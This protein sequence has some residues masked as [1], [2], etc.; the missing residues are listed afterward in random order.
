MSICQLSRLDEGGQRSMLTHNEDATVTWSPLDCDTYQLTQI[1][2]QNASDDVFCRNYPPHRH[3]KTQTCIETNTTYTQN[4]RL[5]LDL[6]TLTIVINHL[7]F[8]LDRLS[9]PFWQTHTG[10]ATLETSANN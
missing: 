4:D 3:F 9:F 7:L 10:T 6:I 2:F 1:P 5:T 8:E